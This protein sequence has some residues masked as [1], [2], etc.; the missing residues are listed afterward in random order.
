VDGGKRLAPLTP[1]GALVRGEGFSEHASAAV[2]ALGVAKLHECAAVSVA[3]TH[4]NIGLYARPASAAGVLDSAVARAAA[5]PEAARAA[6]AFQTETAEKP[7]S[8][9][10]LRWRAAASVVP[11]AFER[12]LASLSENVDGVSA[13]RALRAFLMQTRWFAPDAP[14]GAVEGARLDLFRALPVFETADGGAGGFENAAGSSAGPPGSLGSAGGPAFRALAGGSPFRLLSRGFLSPD[15]EKEEEQTRSSGESVTTYPDASLL[16]PPAS[17]ALDPDLLPRG[18]FLKLDADGDGALLESRRL[19]NR[20]TVTDALVEHVLPGLENGSVSKRLASRVLDACVTH[21]RDSRAS[22]TGAGD[23][24]RTRD[25]VRRSRCVPTRRRFALSSLESLSDSDESLIELKR[26]GDLFDPR[27]SVIAAVFDL[28]GA[29]NDDDA[30]RFFPRAPFDE[31]RRADALVNEFGVKKKLGAEG[32]L[33]AARLVD[34]AARDDVD[35]GSAASADPVRV[36]AAV[37][38]GAALLAYLDALAR[39]AIADETLPEEDA[40]AREEEEGDF[41]STESTIPF[42]RALASVAFVPALRAAPEAGMPWPSGPRGK[43]LHALAPPSATRPP[44]DAWI[45]SSCLRVLDVDAVAAAAGR[46]SLAAGDVIREEAG[47]EELLAGEKDSSAEESTKEKEK[48]KETRLLSSF[49]V[50]ETLATR[51]GWDAVAPAAVAA[52]LLELGGQFP[53]GGRRVV[54]GGAGEGRRESTKRIAECLNAS[55]PNAYAVLQNASRDEMD[56]AATILQNAPWV[57]TGAGFAASADVAAFASASVS[58]EP[59]L[60]LVPK[61]LSDENARPLLEAF[62]VRDRFRAVD[63]ARAASRLAADAAGE[64]I[65]ERRVALA[66]ALADAAADAL[67]EYE[68]DV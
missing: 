64:P 2:A 68:N 61:E 28:D 7:E 3:A 59:Y 22:W 33:L 52:Q 58:F 63:F 13:R 41:E 26:P 43:P 15:V 55:L 25:A 17:H 62:G 37:R 42:W 9:P 18:A 24:E 35:G 6:E 46:E 48:E 11:G 32:I 31:G 39:G 51:L 45:S 53:R 29:R 49:V 19:A 5:T 12:R 60:F 54:R 57:W 21:V 1:H 30:N 67:A 56:A 23:A 10:E 4:L 20:V 65:G 50:H 44:R 14:G 38:R 47:D 36:A 40:R 27:V 66:A 34:A 16:L 8:V